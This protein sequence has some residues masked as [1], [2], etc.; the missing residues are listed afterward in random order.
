MVIADQSVVIGYC[1]PGVVQGRFA[2]SLLAMVLHSE[3]LVHGRVAKVSGPRVAAARNEIV[4]HF[5]TTDAEWL[6]MV[7]ADMILPHHLLER[8]SQVADA[9]ERPIVGGLCFSRDPDGCPFA[10]LYYVDE[11]KLLHRLTQWPQG[12]VVEVHATGAACLLIHRRV[13]EAVADSDY[14]QVWPEA[15]IGEDIAF[16]LQ[17]VSLGFPIFV[18]TSLNVGHVKAQILDVDKY[19]E[20]LTAH[21]FVATGTGR[22]GTRYLATLMSETDLPVGHEAAFGPGGF[23]GWPLIRGDCSWLALPYLEHLAFGPTTILHLTR[24]PLDVL[25][26]L[27]GIGFWRDDPDDG[28]L[29]YR[30]FAEQVA[31]DVMGHESEVARA[32]RW[33]VEANDLAASFRDHHVRVEAIG[34][35]DG[36]AQLLDVL[37]ISRKADAIDMALSRVPTNVNSRRRAEIDWADLPAGKLRARFAD[38]IEALGYPREPDRERDVRDVLGL[39]E[40]TRGAMQTSGLPQ[41]DGDLVTT[42]THLEGLHVE[43]KRHKRLRVPTW[44][45]EIE[46]R[47]S[48]PYLLVVKRWGIADVSHAYALT[49]L[50]TAARWLRGDAP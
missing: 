19:D 1:H 18:D 16:C 32:M 24:H 25:R 12:K 27:V 40:T 21:R 4:E 29:P 35:H 30:K 33:I 45:A 20:Y 28:H 6:L 14:T 43:C 15:P 39:A 44:V 10:T 46:G 2:D 37:G 9:D 22:C 47:T 17:A 5:L 48:D 34:N 13:L 11:G 3:R 26:S 41:P 42:G 38:Q 49:D 23:A 7:D 31:P 50:R 36:Y 8:L